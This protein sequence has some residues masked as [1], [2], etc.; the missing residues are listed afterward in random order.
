MRG[1]TAYL[2]WRIVQ[3]PIVLVVVTVIIFSLLH[4]TPG[5]PVELMLGEYATPESVAALRH[6]YQLDQPLYQQYAFWLLRAIHGDLGH[7]IRQ[8]L[9]VSAMLVRRFPISLE[10]AVFAMAIAVA[11]AVPAG[12]AAA[13][14]RNSAVD[15]VMTGLSVGGLSL[16][17]FALA[18]FLIYVFAVKLRWLPIVGIGASAEGLW[19]DLAPFVLPSFA[20]GVQQMAV[21]SRMLRSSMLEVLHQDYV[22][23]AIAKG[24]TPWAVVK[25]HALRNALIPVV[26]VVAIQFAYLIGTTIT[27]E[28]IF[29]IPGMGSAMLDAVNMR[30]F[31]VIQGFALFVAIVFIILNLVA[32][33]LYT[34]LDPRVTYA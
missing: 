23:T 22:R 17:N 4:V 29:G 11:V 20:L 7:S 10:L 2:S 28:F 34:L 30:D 15:Y 27:I 12:L 19:K 3:L 33:V 14:W 31:P 25:R 13:V 26:T 9:P 8:S 18:L 1:T 16:P 5:D 24:L 21:I 32:D 6:Q